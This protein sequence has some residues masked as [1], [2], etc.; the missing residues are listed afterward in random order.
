MRVLSYGRQ[1]IDQEDI[2]AVVNVLK[3]DWLTQG[4][5][6]DAFEKAFGEYT[7][8]RHAVAFAN[9]T[10]AL[11]GAY[12]AAGVEPGSETITTPM[13]FAA[14]SN[15]ALYLGGSVVFA[16]IDPGTLCLDPAKVEE[17]ITDA[18]RVIAPVS[19]AGYPADMGRFRSLADKSGAILIEDGCHALGARRGKAPVGKE[20]D[21]T[22]FS[23]HPVKH[24]TTGEGGMVVTNSDEF[25]ERL[26]LF[27]THGITKDPAAMENAPD[28]PWSTEMQ[29]LGFNYRLSDIHAA[30]GLSQMRKLD[31][32]TARRREIAALYDELFSPVDA[33]VVPPACEGHAY[34]LYP[35]QVPAE[36]RGE[37]M[38]RLGERGI[39]GMVH[40]PPVHL[41]PYYRR[42]FG[43]KKGD[44]PEAEGFY[45]REISLPI[46]YG[47]TDDEVRRVAE[48]IKIIAES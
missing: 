14:T 23:F 41:H 6:V 32:F 45:S 36:R 22:V 24:I 31:R 8:A 2:E 27:R 43:W 42:C 9:G 34:H 20:A 18:T 7:G 12:F 10:A 25:A 35:L 30:L 29:V 40:Y 28:G 26:R 19:F 16:D 39:R 4:P 21:L 15:G 5:S 33:V 46:F 3:G 47:L 37:F 17:K 44:F 1:Y 11:H 48:E 38:A 13:T